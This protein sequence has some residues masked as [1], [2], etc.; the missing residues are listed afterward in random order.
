MLKLKSDNMKKSYLLMMAGS[1]L[2]SGAAIG[3]S[4]Q[5][6]INRAKLGATKQ[7]NFEGFKKSRANTNAVQEKGAL[8]WEDDCSSAATWTFANTSVPSTDFSIETDANL[9]NLNVTPMPADLATFGSTTASNGFLWI[10]SDAAPNNADNDGTP[11]IAEATSELID[12]TGSPNV[13]LTFE[14]SYRWWQDARGVR[15]SGDD[16]ATWTDY[17][18]TNNAGSPDDQNSMNPEVTQIDI[19]AVAGNSSQV[20]IQF[21]YD[22]NDFWGWYWAVDDVKINE[23]DEFDLID[24]GVYW[25]AA[26]NIGVRVPYYQVPL[27]QVTAY[28]ISGIVKNFGFANQTDVVYTADVVSESFSSSSAASTVNAFTTDTIALATQ[29]TPSGLGEYIIDGDVSSGATDAVPG[30][31]TVAGHDTMNVVQHIYARDN[32]LVDGGFFPEV[33][34]EGGNMFDI[35]QD[36]DLYAIDAQFGASTAAGIEV[37]GTL[38]S[39]DANGEFQFE[40][41]TEYYTTQAGDAGTSRSFIFPNEIT[42]TAGSTYLVTIGSFAID[43]SIAVA[44]ASPDQTSF[45]Y[46]DLGTGGVDWYFTN[47]TPMVRMNFDPSLSVDNAEATE[48]NVSIYPNPANEES[49]VNFSLENTTDVQITVTDLSGKTVFTT[50]LNNAAKGQHTVAIPTAKLSNGVYIVNYNAGNAST[51]KKLVVNK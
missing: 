42:L 51:A 29:F 10:S 14:H 7:S 44:G 5:A 37:Y 3:Q 6:K 35:N 36:A 20:R 11:I 33:A 9:E 38:Y 19:S 43:L 25:G 23:A 18:V 26:G 34:F 16:G 17:E 47:S 21:Y 28:D 24:E 13:I 15:V 4:S 32:G 45:L 46:G 22:D 50:S 41:E 40:A 8:L 31:N 30:N 2:L 48:A 27:E 49:N 12:L 39:I 1:I